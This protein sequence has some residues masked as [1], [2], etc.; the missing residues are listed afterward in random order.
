MKSDYRRPL[1]RP[2][3]WHRDALGSLAW[4]VFWIGFAIAL[5]ALAYLYGQDI[6]AWLESSK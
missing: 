6:A 2:P 3:S 1:N 4:S 5:P